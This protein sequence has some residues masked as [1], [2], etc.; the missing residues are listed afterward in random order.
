MTYSPREMT[1]AHGSLGV[2]SGPAPE[3]NSLSISVG[4]GLDLAAPGVRF[5]AF[6]RPSKRAGSPQEM[7]VSAGCQ[8]HKHVGLNEP[9][10]SRVP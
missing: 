10:K 2:F 6:L 1:R 8:M 9:G 7:G 3:L 4:R 5:G